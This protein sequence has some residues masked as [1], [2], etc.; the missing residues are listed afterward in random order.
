ML[1]SV[2][3]QNARVRPSPARPV[4][5]QIMGAGSLDVLNASNISVTGIGVRVPHRFEGCDLAAEVELVVTL[6]G[7]RP[8]LAGGIIRHITKAGTPGDLFG[9]EFTRI[10]D[11][12]LSQVR[13]YVE[14]YLQIQ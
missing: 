9:I 5:V 3:R 1:S 12:H 6:P 8:F 4:E 11:E 10:S 7:R 13:G 2:K 14:H